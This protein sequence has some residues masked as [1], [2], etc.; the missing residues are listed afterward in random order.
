MTGKN[1]LIAG[2]YREWSQ[3]GRDSI[4]DQ[5]KSM[6]IFTKQ[7]DKASEKTQHV[8]ILGDVN[9]CSTKWNQDNFK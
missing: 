5:I 9:L 1:T 8:L 7:I 6:D 3:N 2:F 4:E